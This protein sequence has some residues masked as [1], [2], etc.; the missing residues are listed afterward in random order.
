MQANGRMEMSARNAIRDVPHVRMVLTANHALKENPSRAQFARLNAT[1]DSTR[2]A[3]SAHNATSPA[4]LAMAV[5][6]P[7][8]QSAMKDICFS[9]PHAHLGV[10]QESTL[11]AK[12]AT[13]APPRALPAN[14][15]P[16]AIVVHQVTSCL[17]NNAF[18]PAPTAPSQPMPPKPAPNAPSLAPNAPDQQ[19]TIASPA[20][21]PL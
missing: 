4:L 10:S 7:N 14:L 17:L 9:R 5:Q 8:A 20:A 1:M 19:V 6:I 11:T 3:R 13:P 16:N 12:S 15:P 2:I 18:K 21:N